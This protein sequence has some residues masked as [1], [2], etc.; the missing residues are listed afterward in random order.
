VWKIAPFRRA[1]ALR[2]ADSGHIAGG[3]PPEA[4]KYQY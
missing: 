2:L 3:Q 1:D 4:Q